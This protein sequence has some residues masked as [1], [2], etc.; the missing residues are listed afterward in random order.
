[1]N[2]EIAYTAKALADIAAL[3]EKIRK[4]VEKKIAG[5][6]SWGGDVKKLEGNTNR[7]RL[8]SGDFRILFEIRKGVLVI[9]ILEVLD[10]KEAYD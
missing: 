8:R 10:R 9:V 5:L 7:Y 6:R 3:P 2:Y 1:M 4:Q